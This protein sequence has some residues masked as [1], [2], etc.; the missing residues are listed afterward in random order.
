MQEDKKG[1]PAPLGPLPSERQ[2]AWHAME[3]YGF[4]HFTVNT[5]TDKEWGY[6]D[7]SPSIFNPSSL[8]CRQWAQAA[9]DAGMKGLVLTTKH[10]DGFC[11]W[12]S[13]FTEH[14][15]KNS[16]WRD[17]KGNV[18]KEFSE[19]CREQGLK[20]GFY[21]SP[22][23]RNHAEYAKPAY[24]DYYRNQLEEILTGY[25]EIFE[26]W[27][28]GANGG[29]GFYGG[30]RET[31][32]IEAATYYGWEKNIEIVR[33]LQPYACMF[34]DAGPDI[35]WIG[36][37]EGLGAETCWMTYTTE[38]RHPGLA[39]IKVLGTGERD[40]KQWV[41]PECDV[42]IRPG[43][44]WHEKE[45]GKVRT[46]ENLVDLYFK[47]VGRGGSLHLNIP[48]DRRGLFHENDVASLR[49][50]R[51]I[52]DAMFRKNFLL[53]GK[54][55]ASNVRGGSAKFAA[56]NVLDGDGETYWATDDSEKKSEIVIDLPRRAAFNVVK[57][58]EH[59]P[60]GQ[61]VDEFAVDSWNG[62]AWV[63]FAS[64]TSIGPRRLLKTEKVFTGR[65]RLRILKA[66]ACPC[67]SEV[68]AYML[69]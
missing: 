46:P 55:S 25:G 4:V 19:A 1:A 28:D 45:N 26:V 18:L 58:R 65:V 54:A 21:L 23:D 14:S 64:G 43:W 62:S 29:D 20:V 61:R 41:P 10:H 69:A 3:F 36:N 33:R 44:F 68:G 34:S 11:L 47:S 38:K 51:K 2:L 40:G 31:R 22:W 16:P 56:G 12:P 13:K 9:K 5:W 15:V 42:S 57:I 27:F 49:G 17:G 30:A 35:R 48:P 66:A 50:M 24:V 32:K 63:Q 7:E 59:I 67:I 6:G 60:L 37:E 52:L 53:G 8:D 39:D